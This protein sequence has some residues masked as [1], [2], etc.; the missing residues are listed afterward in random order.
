MLPHLDRFA[1]VWVVD[2][3]FTAPAG[4]H[5]G[6]ICCVAVEVWSG[7][8]TCLWNE[9]L[10]AAGRPP[11]DTGAA[12]LFVAYYASAEIGCHLALDW[13]V[14]VN[15]LDLYAE[16]RN[17]TNGL[18]LPCGNSL[19]GA[20]AWLGLDVLDVADKDRMRA[21]AGRGGPWTAAE[22]GALLGYCERDARALIS[23]LK[24][25]EGIDLERAL[26]RGRYA[27][28]VAQME[29]LGVPI[30]LEMYRLLKSGWSDIRDRL[31]ER[32]DVDYGVFQGQ[33]FKAARWRRWVE[34][35]GIPWPRLDSGALALDRNTFREMAKAHPGVAAMSELRTTL[36]QTM[37]GGLAI[38][39]DGRN[40]SLLSPFSA[41]TGRNQPSGTRFIFGPAV[42][43]RCLIRPPEGYGL[44]YADWCQQE[45]G[46]AAALSCDVAMMHAY[47]SGDPYLTFA[48]QAGAAPET[49]TRDTHGRVRDRFKACALGVLYGMGAE[50]LGQRIGEPAVRARDLIAAHRRTYPSYWRW[51]D[52]TV[53]R[54]TFHR[55]LQ[56]VFGWT[57][58][59]RHPVNER[60]LRN[61]PIQGNGAEML[62]LACC[63]ATERGIRVCA[64]IHDA[65][66]VEARLGELEGV[67]AETQAVLAEASA[68]VLGGFTLRS[69]VK[70]I[71]YPDRF[72][73]PRGERMWCLVNE[74]L[75]ELSPPSGEH[76]TLLKEGL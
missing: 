14:P 28:A 43:V 54:A 59:L 51:S 61:F 45:F 22:R 72:M 75:E 55:Q 21:L 63:M 66:L 67:V 7:R 53:D 9:G 11:Y 50:S 6:P 29:R 42:W 68:A 73:D 60:S 12:S 62:R 58:H 25:M 71:R 17:L 18:A 2:F 74:L 33:T 35:Q 47:E 64:P 19:I 69:D 10:Q 16:F 49:A 32:V 13:P 76:G 44:V 38:G 37:L 3:E 56:T 65:L 30:E 41:K 20:L 57:L 31:I 5:P 8:R 52:E 70:I 26:L 1:T 34:Q 46:I 39:E 27:V 24:R 48:Q 36:S 40:R 4:E 23:V 15:V